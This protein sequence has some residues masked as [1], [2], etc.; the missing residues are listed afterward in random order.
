MIKSLG[1]FN[2]LI[3]NITDI[4][5]SDKIIYNDDTGSKTDVVTLK[6]LEQGR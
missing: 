2:S 5:L 1:V 3:L 4:M 6:S